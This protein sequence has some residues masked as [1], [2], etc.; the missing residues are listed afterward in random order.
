MTKHEHTRRFADKSTKAAREFIER[1]A[2]RVEEATDGVSARGRLLGRLRANLQQVRE[3]QL[4]A[5]LVA[6]IEQ[7][8]RNA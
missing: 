3:P 6:S 2:W 8:D 5:R 4:R 7:L 1:G